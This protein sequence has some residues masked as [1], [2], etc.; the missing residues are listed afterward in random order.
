MHASRT[1]HCSYADIMHASHTHHCSYA[2]IMRASHTHHCSYAGIMH[3]SHT[4]HMRTAPMRRTHAQHTCSTQAQ[5]QHHMHAGP[6]HPAVPALHQQWSHSWRFSPCC[7]CHCRCRAR[8]DAELKQLGQRTLEMAWSYYGREAERIGQKQV[9]A[10]G[11]RQGGHGADV[12]ICATA[13]WLRAAG[14]WPPA[15]CQPGLRQCWC[16]L[17]LLSWQR[18]LQLAL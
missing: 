7:H 6:C 11:S 1:H 17:L 10:G 3:A 14:G 15:A 2:D 5:L 16:L 9:R 13:A 8:N 12:C 18:E 4:H